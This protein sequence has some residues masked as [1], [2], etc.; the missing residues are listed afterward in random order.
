MDA[1]T[2]VLKTIAHEEPD[3]VPAFESAFTNNTIMEHYGV[4]SEGGLVGSL[5]ILRFLPFKERIANWAVSNRNFLKKAYTKSYE[6]FRRVKIDIGLSLVTHTQRKIIK[7]GII[8]EFGRIMKFEVYEKDGTVITGY[9]GG[10]FESFEDYESWE[11]PDPHE[12]KRLAAFYAGKDVQEEMNNEIFSVP[13]IGGMMENSWEA[14]GLEVFSR[15]LA[16]PKHAKKVFDDHGHLAVELTKILADNGA[17]LILIW[18]D[19]GFKNGPFMSP[20]NYRKYVF[21]WLKRICDEAHKRGSKILLHSDGDLMLLF[22]DIVNC[23]VDAL[24]PIES[25]TANPEY[26]IFKLNEKY[27]DQITFVGNISPVM[28]AVGKIDEI[29]EYSKKLIR[30]LAPGGGY[31]FSSGHSINPAITLDRWEAVMEIR[32]RYSS[33]PIDVP[34]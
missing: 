22:D 4:Q 19:Y 17:E 18:D 24:N 3:R 11:R 21:P 27:G 12:P 30:E 31:I 34:L 10:Y 32:D 23:G 16:K 15:I 7:G 1:P 8:D 26:D 13:A 6:F 33:Y 2:R 20:K 25:T 5:K 29:K 9:H 28:L 14:F